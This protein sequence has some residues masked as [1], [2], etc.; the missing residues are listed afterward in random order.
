LS[1][2]K[3]R[4][5]AFQGLYSWDVSQ[6]PLEDILKFS[7]IQ[8][9]DGNEVQGEEEVFAAMIISGTVE[10][11]AE[12][13]E[14]IK[15]HLSSNWTLERINKVTLAILRT[16]VYEIKYQAG[17]EPKIVIDEAINI[18]HEFGPQDSYKFINAVLD[19]IGKEE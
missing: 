13:D 11:V 4:I 14:L 8:N 9:D 6:S 19:K 7:W 3:G 15:N 10:H 16:S 12:I 17:S 5:L 1:R 2:R 18:A